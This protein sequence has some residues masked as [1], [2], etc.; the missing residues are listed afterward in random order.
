MAAAIA[1]FLLSAWSLVRPMSGARSL[2][3]G[4]RYFQGVRR[5]VLQEWRRA[6]TEQRGSRSISNRPLLNPSPYRR[7]YKEY[8]SGDY[9]FSVYY[10][11]NI[12]PQKSRDRG[13][14]LTVEFQKADG[15][16]GFQIFAAPI[17]GTTITEERFLMDE[18][19]GVRKDVK[20]V[21]VDGVQAVAFHG[22]D[23][24]IGKTY[25]V[26][27][28]RDGLLY[29]ISTYKRLEPWLNKIL[30]TWRFLPNEM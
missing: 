8:R 30:S 2:A 14:A 29:E 6:G 4:A 18:P 1:L 13:F 26:W 15:E 17:N 16:P 19:S 22:F 7:G 24:R 10:P 20:D 27:F 5:L 28:I 25:E 9:N 3:D 21:S 23:A 12:P 11:G